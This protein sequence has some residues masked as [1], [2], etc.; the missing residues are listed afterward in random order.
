VP[1]PRPEFRLGI[2][3]GCMTHQR[4]VPLN[5]LYH[6]Q[7]AGLLAERPGIKLRTHVVRAF[8]A[9]LASR[10]ELLLE[11]APVDGVL[12]HLRAAPLVWSVRIVRRAWRD[13]QFQTELNPALNPALFRGTAAGAGTQAFGSGVE[14]DDAYG[15]A[16]DLQDRP[17]TGRRIAGMRVRNLNVAAGTIVGLDR[18]AI[19]RQLREFAALERAAR[20]RG[21][22]LFVLG[23]T[24][25]T[26]SW[27]TNRLVRKAE[28]VIRQ[29][30]TGTPVPF[31]LVESAYDDAGRPVIRADGTHLTIDGH[32]YVAGRL[33]RA[34]LGDWMS[35]ILAART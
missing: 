3:G 20:A 24:P 12:V 4:G 35:R 14:D 25:T 13:G 31:A 17:P 33:E 15:G 29:A 21:V 2:I 19:R 16:P 30:L 26:Y 18:I 5:A 10:L 27:W 22:S 8:D 1:E 9:D 11:D 32:R 6:R 23:P 28:A 34:G 7:L